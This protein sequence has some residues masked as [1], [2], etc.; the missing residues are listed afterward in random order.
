SVKTPATPVDWVAQAAMLFDASGNAVSVA[1]PVPVVMASTPLPT[2]SA[3]SANQATQITALQSLVT[4]VGS[5]VLT[6]GHGTAAAALRVE[7]PTDGTGVVNIG[8]VPA[9]LPDAST[10]S[11]TI[12]NGASL[13]GQV[14]LAGQ[15]LV[16]LIMPAAWTTASLTF[17]V[18][19]TSGGTDYALWDGMSGSEVALSSVGASIWLRIDPS[20]FLGVR[21]I[22][23]LSGTHGTP[24]NQGADRIIKLVTRP[25]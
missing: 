6:S 16:G 9:V 21:Y 24:V 5:A 11:V 22:K 3:T 25:V 1:N 2:G 20:M 8:T 17:T 4:A 10:L 23:L 14:D 7:L 19:P 18:S 15:T 13:S 12:A